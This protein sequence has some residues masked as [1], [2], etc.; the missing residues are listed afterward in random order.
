MKK[1][2]SKKFAKLAS[3]GLL[4]TA[5]MNTPAHAQTPPLIGVEFSGIIGTFSSDGLYDMPKAPLFD[6]Q[7][8]VRLNPQNLLKNT[9]YYAGDFISGTD[10]DAVVSVKT[11]STQDG[12]VH[13]YSEKGAKVW[14]SKYQKDMLIRVQSSSGGLTLDQHYSTTKPIPTDGQGMLNF[15]TQ[16]MDK[17]SGPALSQV[18]F[19]NVSDPLIP[20][21]RLSSENYFGT[22]FEVHPILGKEKIGKDFVVSW[23]SCF[24]NYTL[25]ASS[26]L[27]SRSWTTMPAVAT[28]GVSTV[29]QPATE[30]TMFF[31][32]EPKQ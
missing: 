8:S 5:G 32:L 29:T 4:V 22:P 15:L 14:I 28:N 6:T 21:S 23:P 25:K 18:G 20:K 9:L 11:T 3:I 27:G 31:K 24:T 26:D 12:T 7:G 13:T 17:I 10:K 16:E 1:R 19:F 30:P 2:L